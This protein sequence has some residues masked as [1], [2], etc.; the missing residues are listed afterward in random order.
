MA[1]L[2]DRVKANRNREQIVYSVV[3]EVGISTQTPNKSNWTTKLCCILFSSQNWMILSLLTEIICTLNVTRVFA[4]RLSTVKF[5]F[6][7]SLQRTNQNYAFYTLFNLMSISSLSSL[8]SIS[9]FFSF[10]NLSHKYNN[11]QKWS[12]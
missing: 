1:S 2:R 12:L 4:Y 9:L 7:R 5:K 3:K 11:V 6:L 8:L 10:S